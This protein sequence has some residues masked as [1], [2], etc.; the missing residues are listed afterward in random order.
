MGTIDEIRETNDS[1]KYQ[2][3]LMPNSGIGA[4][5]R[6]YTLTA[7]NIHSVTNKLITD[8]A[9]N[10]LSFVF[11]KNDLEDVFVYPNPAKMTEAD[12]LYFANLSINSKIIILSLDG[13]E[14]QQLSENDGNGGVYWD[15]RDKDGID[16]PSGIY[17][18]KVEMTT[19]KG[20]VLVS[21]PKKFAIV[22]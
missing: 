18:Y 5:G 17:L 11:F 7:K 8:G 12:G 4:F 14:I 21:D 22:R 16:L 6:T 9:G 1:S 13:K 19:V 20:S 3:I 2:I 15:G 10:T